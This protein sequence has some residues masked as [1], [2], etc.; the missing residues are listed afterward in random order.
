MIT[1]WFDCLDLTWNLNSISDLRR[2]IK[3]WIQMRQTSV[4]F[5]LY[6]TSLMWQGI[7]GL[8][9][10]VRKWPPMGASWRF[11]CSKLVCVERVLSGLGLKNL[12]QNIIAV[13]YLFFY[14]KDER[15]YWRGLYVLDHVILILKV[16]Q[17]EN[18]NICVCET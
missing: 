10:M 3:I 13:C 5:V 4:L 17:N 11:V 18:C 14:K 16:S 2:G 12:L 6:F 8:H 7:G 15:T 1:Y 9:E